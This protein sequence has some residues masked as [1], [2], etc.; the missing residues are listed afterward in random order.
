M[1][2]IT[3]VKELSDLI[4]AHEVPFHVEDEW[5]VPSSKLPAI[6][7]K[8]YPREDN[9]LLEVDVL[10][11]DERIINECFAGIGSGREGINDAL[12]NFCVNSFHVLLASLWGLNIPDQ[13]MTENWNLEGKEYTAYIGNFGTRGSAEVEAEIPDG[14]FEVIEKAIKSESLMDKLSWFRC[15]FCDVSGEQTFEALKNNEVWESGVSALK[16]L[17]WLKTK[18]Y[19]SVRNFLV[20]RENA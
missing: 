18:G 14:L 19:Y 2:P 20:L 4:E 1:E 15:F 10:L 17:P 16:S 12:Q 7:A 3:L 5:V 8:W 11:E 13:V 9:G 6:R